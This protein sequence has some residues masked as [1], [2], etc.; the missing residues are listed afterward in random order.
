[1]D[2]DVVFTGVAV[3]DLAGAQSW[4]ERLLGRPADIPVADDEVMWHIADDAWLYIVVDAERA[5]R[6]LVAMAVRDLDGVVAEIE[7][8]GVVVDSV[9]EV[10]DAGR[11]ASTHDPDGN[12]IAIIAVS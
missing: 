6:S 8:R 4:Y 3:S 2:V 5:G 10:G 7:A 1:M 9:E 12:T 11:K